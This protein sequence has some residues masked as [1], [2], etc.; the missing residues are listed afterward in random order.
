[1][2]PKVI[3]HGNLG[4]FVATIQNQSHNSYSLLDLVV[5]K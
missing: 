1:M 2:Y 5:R 3:R 4:W